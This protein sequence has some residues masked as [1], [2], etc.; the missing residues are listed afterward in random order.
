MSV[1]DNPL[2]ITTQTNLVAT[3]Q[4]A[5]VGIAPGCDAAIFW[6]DVTA[7]SGTSPTLD[8]AIQ[9]GP[10]AAGPFA[11]VAS[12]AITQITAVGVTRHVVTDCGPFVRLNMVLGGTSP[13]FTF[14]VD[15]VFETSP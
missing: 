15:A 5:A 12:G 6:V 13:D 3:A 7:E 10:T 9:D 8:I 2:Q 1:K 14:T 4:S 11:T